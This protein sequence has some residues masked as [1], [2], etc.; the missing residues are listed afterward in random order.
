MEH[1]NKKILNYKLTRFIGEGGMASVYEGTHEKLGTKVAI[2]ILNPI[3]TANKQIRLRFENE[4]KFMAS[5][6]H[7]NIT[8]VIDFDEQTDLLAIIMELLEGQ[9]LSNLIKSKGAL[10]PDIA[11]PIFSQ[12]LDAFQY[13]HSKGIVHR[14]IKPSNIYLVGVN[15]VKILDFGIAKIFGSG[16]DFTST[17]TQIGTPVYMSP[18]QV[19]A[20]KSIDHR[21][22]IYSLGVTLFFALNG[23]PPY[24]STTQSNFEIFN[25]IVFEPIPDLIQYPEIN[26]IIKTSVAKD[27]NQRFQES[28]EFKNELVKVSFQLLNSNDKDITIVEKNNE[29]KVVKK[30]DDKTLID[31]TQFQK[32][33]NTSKE[34]EL[35]AKEKDNLNPKQE[36]QILE[37]NLKKTTNELD[38]DIATNKQRNRIIGICLLISVISVILFFWK[39]WKTSIPLDFDRMSLSE[40]NEFITNNPNSPLIIKAKEKIETINSEIVNREKLLINSLLDRQGKFT[41]K[42]DKKIYKTIEIGTQ[43]WFAENLNY[44]TVG[45]FAYDNNEEYA[46]KYGRLYAKQVATK[47]CPSGWHTATYEDWDQLSEY[48]F[49]WRVDIAGKW[50]RDSSFHGSNITGL[51]ILPGGTGSDGKFSNI[52]SYT[53]FWSGLG[54]YQIINSYEDGLYHSNSYD[55]DLNDLY[56]IRCVK[57]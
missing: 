40:C 3:L 37:G 46:K 29:K 17:G 42:R 44:D 27:R 5:L 8:K 47:V 33:E 15:Q 7:P 9:D 4:A 56:Y 25:K 32:H 28:K 11:I 16:D 39:P 41:D 30:S 53:N 48:L 1:I 31:K 22:D 26:H 57:D 14:D 52:G 12:I 36:A 21:S 38:D 54:S 20:D 35:I 13:A 18:E 43:I 19:K 45:S 34:Q 6:N 10:K 50:T 49:G 55:D 2:K 51:T 23:K 24:D